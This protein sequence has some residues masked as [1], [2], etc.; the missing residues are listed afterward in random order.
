VTFDDG[1]RLVFLVLPVLILIAYVLLQRRRHAVALRFTSVDLLASVAPRRSG[2]QRHIGA[3]VM[4][5]ALV[6]L[7]VGFAKPEQVERTPRQRATIM[8][9]LDVSGSMAA[10]DVTPS[11]LAAAQAQAD[12][13]VNGLPATLQVGLVSFDTNAQVLV[14]PTTDHS[15]VL[16][17]IN[18]LQ[19]GTGTATGTAINLSLQAIKTV[20]KPAD[21][22]AVPAAIVLMSDGTPTIGDGDVSP[23][24]SA[25]NAARAAKAAGIPVDTIAFGT[26]DGIVT[27]RG[28]EIPV[29]SDP[30][31][32][33]E[34]ASESGG[35]TFTA[36]SSQQLGSVYDQIGRAVGYETH[37]HEITVWF[38][39]IALFLA[40]LSAG[41]ALY[42]SQRIV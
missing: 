14:S 29:P 13:F 6:L 10:T 39:G 26:A 21:G 42:W 5:V 33:Q 16:A 11:R 40:A 17:A 18:A 3:S 37:E 23:Q 7:T 8:L 1:W 31:A 12:R 2:W 36:E 4:L 9:T 35:T 24:Q 30:A 32:M 28:Q 19:P 15:T 38:T 34:I 41:A 22:K 25:D 27:V 20:P